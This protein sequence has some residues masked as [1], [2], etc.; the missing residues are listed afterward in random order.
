MGGP[1]RRVGAGPV[2]SKTNHTSIIHL[3]YCILSTGSQ[4]CILFLVLSSR[5]LAS[6]YENCKD[7]KLCNNIVYELVNPG[8]P[9]QGGQKEE[10]KG[11]Q[12]KKRI[13]KAF[14]DFSF[15]GFIVQ[16]I[17]DSYD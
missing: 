6:E 16:I 5:T 4:S 13:R 10:F 17:E 7:L 9:T 15:D 1:T 12:N 11:D 2:Q 3:S 14:I 8:N